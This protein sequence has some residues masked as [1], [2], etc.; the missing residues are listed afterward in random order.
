MFVTNVYFN[1]S[2]FFFFYFN[3]CTNYPSMYN[4]LYVQKSSKSMS[5]I[6]NEFPISSLKSVLA[7]RVTTK[8]Y[9][10]AEKR[11]ILQLICNSLEWNRNLLLILVHACYSLPYSPL[12]CYTLLTI[13]VRLQVRGAR[14]RGI[15]NR[16][17]RKPGRHGIGQVSK[18][19]M[20]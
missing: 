9:R 10:N 13:L 4:K 12:S 20:Q 3:I 11:N 18:R 6:P 1:I 17:D 5:S 14:T 2:F 7:R 16:T 19:N 8:Q 15:E